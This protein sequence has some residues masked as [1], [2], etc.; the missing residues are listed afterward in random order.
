MP[1][2]KDLSFLPAKRGSSDWALKKAEK[3]QDFNLL[4]EAAF[5]GSDD[6]LT[7]RYVEMFEEEVC[8]YHFHAVLFPKNILSERVLF[9][10]FARH[11]FGWL[12]SHKRGG[13][14]VQ[15][16]LDTVTLEAHIRKYPELYW[17]YLGQ[18]C[19]Y[20]EAADVVLRSA[21][22]EADSAQRK[23]VSFVK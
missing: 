19:R 15:L 17:M 3:Y 18:K 7:A 13:D 23:M 10:D 14:A 12:L 8:Y 20:I 2:F 4:C 11:A 5:D 16:A 22:R 1:L 21:L 9:Q 6:S